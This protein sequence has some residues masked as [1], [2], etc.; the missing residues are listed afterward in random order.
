M[1]KLF[2]LSLF[3]WLFAGMNSLMASSSYSADP[4][5]PV[6]SACT[7]PAVLFA[8]NDEVAVQDSE[9]IYCYDETVTVTLHTIIVGPAPISLN[10][11]VLK[12]G[13]PFPSHTAIPLSNLDIGSV[14]FSDIL[15]PG[16]Y[17]LSLNSL[18]S[19]EPCTASVVQ[20]AMYTAT[21]IIVGADDV[22]I[23]AVAD[24]Y[25]VAN[26][27]IILPFSVNYPDFSL[28]NIASGTMVNALVTTTLPNGFPAGAQIFD[29]HYNGT[30]VLA[31]PYSIA[32][33]SEILLSTI[34]GGSPYPL[35]G[36]SNQSDDWKI[37]I[38]GIE[39]TG[40]IPTTVQSIAYLDIN[41]CYA[42][43]DEQ[44]F[45]VFV[46]EISITEIE[47]VSV[48][49]KDSI[50]ISWTTSYP[51][52]TLDP[53]RIW[54]DSK[55]TFYSD[56]AMT[57]PVS[58]P[59][60]TKIT[61]ATPIG[62]SWTS[63]L[64]SPTNV[65][66]GSAIVTQQPNPSTN[67][68]GFILPLAR[69]EVENIWQASIYEMGY[70]AVYVKFENLALLDDE[71][72]GYPYADEYVFATETFLA[73]AFENPTVSCPDNFEVCVE[74]TLV[75]LE[76]LDV[77]PPSNISNSSF[78][79]NAV[80]HLSALNGWWDFYPDQA[81]AGI[82]TITYTYT[83]ENACSS[84]CDFDI[85]VQGAYEV[86]LNPI[87]DI[88][89]VVNAPIV[90]SFTIDYPD[91]SQQ[92]LIP[93]TLVDAAIGT[94]DQFPAGTRIFDILYNG[95][96][97]LTAPY[98]IG[99]ESQVLLSQ[100]LGVNA[101]PLAGHSNLSDTWTVFVDGIQDQ[102]VTEMAIGSITYSHV[103]SLYC[104]LDFE[105]FTLNVNE[106]EVSEMDV[107]DGCGVDSVILAWTTSYPDINVEEAWVFND[108]KFT[109]FSDE[110]M[111][112]PV[113]LP[114]GT[115]IA[116]LT[117]IGNYWSS[118]LTT[119]TG[120]VYGSAIFTGEGDVSTN[121]FGYIV[122]LARPE[123]THNWEAYI[124]NMTP[125]KYYVKFE[126][127]AL[128]NDATTGYPYADEYAFSTIEFAVEAYELP[129][130][131]FNFNG[132]VVYQDA[133][134]NLCTGESL[135]INLASI[136]SGVAPFTI[137]YDVIK[138]ETIDFILDGTKIGA[139]VVG[140]SANT[141]LFSGILEIGSY[142][143]QVTS[144]VDANGCEASPEML[145]MMHATVVIHG[146]PE[147]EMAYN[148]TYNH[149]MNRYEVCSGDEVVVSLSTIIAGNA[150]FTVDYSYTDGI[151]TVTGTETVDILENVFNNVLP[152]GTYAFSYTGIVDTYGCVVTN[153]PATTE[154]IV[155]EDPF[156]VFAFNEVTATPAFTAEYC[157]S[158]TVTVSL[159]EVWTGTAPFSVAFLVT[160]DGDEFL[161][162]TVSVT[163]PGDILWSGV[164]PA[165]VY[166]VEVTNVTDANGCEA[167]ATSIAYYQATITILPDPFVVL[168]F[169]EETA[170]PGFNQAYC[171]DTEIDVTVSE[172]W[173]GTAPFSITYQ[174][175]N[176]AP[177]TEENLNIYSPL[178]TGY[179]PA[180]VYS[181][182]ISSLVDDNGC[183]AS[184]TNLAAYNGTITIHEE[185]LIEFSF[186]EVPVGAN[187]ELEY[188]YNEAV[189]VQLSEVWGGVAPFTVVY[190]VNGEQE[191]AV[192]EDIS[193]IL[194]SEILLADVYYIE[195]ISITDAN[196]CVT[197][198]SNIA[199]Y[200]GT[201]TINPEPFLTLAFDGMQV[202]QGFSK[203]YCYD[204]NIQVSVYDVWSGDEPFTVTYTINEEEFVEENVIDGFE[205]FNAT[206]EAGTYQLSITS[207]V[208]A[209]N[210]ATSQAM[211]E[212]FTANI[213]V[214]PQPFVLFSF[215]NE[216]A[217]MESEFV[218][219][220]DQAIEVALSAATFG[221]EPF[222]ITYQVNTE[223][224]I[225]EE[226]VFVGDILFE[227][228]QNPGTYV[229]TMLDITDA[230]GCSVST[231]NLEL[232]TATVV[233]NEEPVIG[234]SFN[235]DLAITNSEF[236]FC[237][238]TEVDVTL[239]HIWGGTAPFMV[240][241]SV[242]GSNLELYEEIVLEMGE[243]LWTGYLEPGDYSIQI[244]SITDA[245]GCYASEATIQN[246]VASIHVDAIPNTT[247]VGAPICI[248]GDIVLSAVD[249]I[250]GVNEL[251]TGYCESNSSYSYLQYIT[252]VNVN[253]AINTS[254]S[255]NYS[256]YL[257]DV[258]ST[259]YV[260]STY[261]I[262]V[263]IANPNGHTH[264]LAVY[265]DWNRDGDFE[266]M[267]EYFDLGLNFGNAVFTGNIDVPADA[268]LGY[269]VMRVVNRKN[270]STS[271]C[272]N[273]PVGETEDYLIAIKD[274]RVTGATYAWAGPNSVS[275][276][277]M[278]LSIEEAGM[279]YEGIYTLSLTNAESCTV[280]ATYEL[281][282]TNPIVDFGAPEYLVEA[283]FTMTLNPGTFDTYLWS[284]TENTPTI[285]ASTFGT[286]NVTVSL[287]SCLTE[288]SVILSQKQDIELPFGWSYFS[289]YIN[290][291]ED[292]EVLL[293]NIGD[294]VI[295]VK[296]ASGNTYFGVFGDPF[297]IN[298]IGNIT[299]GT[300]YQIKMAAP[301]T[302]TVVG[303]SVN[304][305]SY[306]IAL[307][308]GGNQI[309]YLRYSPMP[310]DIA[311]E[312]I[313]NDI[314]LVKTNNGLS[315]IPSFDID[316][317]GN[318]IP[319][320]GY[321]VL[322]WENS[323][324]EYPENSMIY[325]AKNITA[326]AIPMFYSAVEN[327]GSD[328]TLVIP[329]SAWN[330][331][332]AMYSEIA[333]LNSRNQV[334]GAA[335]YT[336]DNLSINVWGND[337]T[338]T[339]IEGMNSGE[340][341]SLELYN[342]QT[343][344]ITS[345]E[346]VELLMGTEFYQKDQLVVVKS[347]GATSLELSLETYPNPASDLINLSFVTVNDGEVL[348]Q[349]FNVLG[350]LVGQTI[351]ENLP[352]GEQLI[353]LNVA[354]L[355]AGTYQIQLI[356]EQQQLTKPVVIK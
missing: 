229:I 115:K 6:V 20:L 40:T 275:A 77:I 19:N 328:M 294:D 108:S 111:T 329:T 125:G 265:V 63:T 343:G 251:V 220:Y 119:P 205:F 48:C 176:E 62:N 25:A 206:M 298:D 113:N 325:N 222:S 92:S 342:S 69:N 71:T 238:N 305:S 301:Q 351:R 264:Y 98:E 24:V 106:I 239:S 11:S 57:T 15:E 66:Y 335:V 167:N 270:F 283:P 61:I 126:S 153:L 241:Y 232:Y 214:N 320:F 64:S 260:D 133:E 299:I 208:D 219:C 269:T 174:I 160:T 21:I 307:N 27:P 334:V 107:I 103:D 202:A 46:N 268:E 336:D 148:G 31:S 51:D 99:G 168:S 183:F 200:N 88:Y 318:M 254:S 91:F 354:H 140:G 136:V 68:F 309:A 2:L 221:T 128:L 54:S 282:I 347:M 146:V 291:T 86:D 80:F 93:G 138:D 306:P 12:D 121:E 356:S 35:A 84:S 18:G 124:S 322:A 337:Q 32:S 259:F 181:L 302:L 85:H 276:A 323:S 82:H 163:N 190:E 179:Y 67:Q 319:D 17:T 52:I 122:P 324:I 141:L 147:V 277:G 158:E 28:Q 330:V 245:N 195:I 321:V 326:P 313:V 348:I 257:G 207:I 350:E 266:D 250:E 194:F 295:L 225:Q 311:F 261:A 297:Y 8:F 145:E 16:E 162:E 186:N 212:N 314:I 95:T 341:Y 204:Q 9:F 49:G 237:A 13:I 281:M 345:L 109:F 157:Y 193:Q 249:A 23:D 180:G 89:A 100:I 47:D 156:L 197:S 184:A 224:P 192:L 228:L 215:N 155:Q 83:D 34:L 308:P 154:I 339:S 332:P 255:S 227:G 230:N 211:L 187:F 134:V 110:D 177:V 303:Q 14:L 152:S 129:A 216:E 267:G 116:I 293:A 102:G 312:D 247:I 252:E 118:V 290:T 286:Y 235:N 315:Y 258:F 65:V 317:I 263:S 234:I 340:K 171:Y 199:N 94:N 213:T 114:V 244:L 150:P 210:C 74:E 55:F 81:G 143:I 164:L 70:G 236:V 142:D 280:E 246:Y 292:I 117:P 272:G 169:N 73:G 135:D 218:Y 39:T 139:D 4:A 60:G 41:D 185:P 279:D 188:C 151:T 127:L 29:V 137:V 33:E 189:T 273:Y 243:S 316:Q 130:V 344:E 346:N 296:D 172:I 327:T 56:L 75:I 352:A 285:D 310:I 50:S 182:S 170:A 44:S 161:N 196:N 30:S 42:I 256:D 209:N 38:D 7:P 271:A 284:T 5:G 90:V 3:L 96:S 353:Q 304:P 338:T 173:T 132:N 288:G 248:H 97:V 166:Q 149:N 333:V 26:A 287:N 22:T 105:F 104:E 262:S 59:A 120:V 198:A 349:L 178:F 274:N 123:M 101:S 72:P 112:M 226:I 1:R 233:V 53:T 79:G 37:F 203:E 217:A 144:I 36:H 231:A 223:T 242:I 43:L 300:G 76:G 191:T 78:S 201:V 240:T 253:Q 159:D 175:N 355:A 58:L 331:K 165:G 278:V 10:Y 131:L 87:D 45:N 289:T